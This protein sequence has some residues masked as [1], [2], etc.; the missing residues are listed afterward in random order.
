LAE[1]A[2]IEDE[3]LKTQSMTVEER[4]KEIEKIDQAIGLQEKMNQEAKDFNENTKVGDTSIEIDDDT[5]YLDNT[6]DD[7]GNVK[8]LTKVRDIS[9]EIVTGSEYNADT[10]ETVETGVLQ[11]GSVD[12]M[13]TTFNADASIENMDKLISKQAELEAATQKLSYMEEDL[14]ISME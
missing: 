10:G 3:I 13:T 6:K 2:A 14:K 8:D 9:N 4:D 12:G 5:D 11:T 1:A 7:K